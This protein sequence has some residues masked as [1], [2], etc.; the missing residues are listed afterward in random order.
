MATANFPGDT[1]YDSA[2]SA[3]AP[4]S[5]S[6]VTPTISVTG[7]A[8]TNQ[9]RA[10]IIFHS[11]RHRSAWFNGS[12]W[13]H[14]VEPRG[15][16]STCNVGSQSPPAVSGVSTT[17]TSARFKLTHRAPIPRISHL[18]ATRITSAVTNSASSASVTEGPQT[19][20]ITFTSIPASPNLGD[21]MT[22]PQQLIQPW[23]TNYLEEQ[24][25]GVCQVSWGNDVRLNPIRRK[26]LYLYR[27]RSN[28]WNIYRNSRLFRGQQ[29]LRHTQSSSTINIAKA[30]PTVTIL[31]SGNPT[32][33]GSVAFNAVVTGV[34]TAN[35]PTG[36][37]AWSITG[38]ANTSTCTPTVPSIS[39][40]HALT[41]TCIEHL[42]TVGT[43][44][45]AGV[46][47]GDSNYLSNQRNN[48]RCCHDCFK[49]SAIFASH[50]WRD[51]ELQGCP[52]VMTPWCQYCHMGS[53]QV[54]DSTRFKLV[55][56]QLLCNQLHAPTTRPTT[57]TIQQLSFRNHVLFL[58]QWIS[59]RFELIPQSAKE[60]QHTSLCILPV[61]SP[62]IVPPASPPPSGGLPTL[63]FHFHWPLQSSPAS[64]QTSK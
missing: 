58:G 5:V 53:L 13:R 15:P 4:I 46:Y 50:S 21:S 12:F 56:A 61:Y 28:C 31:H 27:D 24:S 2:N 39:V 43:Y 55:P 32:A 38:T 59:I 60:H 16:S 49:R 10:P 26:C 54:Q 40:A 14:H 11:S 41:F 6:Q 44:V 17:Y 22:L 64:V 25:R 48:P 23:R 35:D 52:V 30:L 36:T 45:A 9:Y 62:P 3:P 57:C 42:P 47:N 37:F 8:L 33:G 1:N 19:P 63:Q 51:Y 20:T 29:L 18:L 7:A 34:N